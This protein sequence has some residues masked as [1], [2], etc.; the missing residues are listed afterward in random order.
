MGSMQ[1][2]LAAGT[3]QTML[4]RFEKGT[5]RLTSYFGTDTDRLKRLIDR[6]QTSLADAVS[7]A[8]AEKL[9]ARWHDPL[10]RLCADPF[11]CGLQQADI[12]SR[13][14]V[15]WDNFS[16][17][18]L[19]TVRGLSMCYDIINGDG[20]GGMASVR[21][22]ALAMP[23]WSATSEAEK[24]VNLANFAA[25]RLSKYREERRARRLNLANVPTPYRGTPATPGR[26]YADQ[27]NR[28]VPNL[29]RALTTADKTVCQKK[30]SSHREYESM[31]LH[32]GHSRVP[33]TYWNERMQNLNGA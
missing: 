31:G 17:L 13:L 11:M 10:S 26:S 21:A 15:A 29:D 20:A 24:L 30:A 8:T 2:N 32:Y 4:A 27:I 14:C 33:V 12:A 18:N 5:S 1:W 28:T 23:A 19:T 3:L 9:A 16:S 25:D 22:R 7:Q 6:Q